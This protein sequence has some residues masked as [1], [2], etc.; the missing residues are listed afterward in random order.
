MTELPEDFSPHEAAE[1]RAE[2]DLSPHEASSAAATEAIGDP[3][4]DAATER[5]D[6]LP[7]RPIDEHPEVFE[8]VHR[9][10]AAA[11]DDEPV[12]DEAGGADDES[13]A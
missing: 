1:G 13:G 4:V 6:D 10:L 9:D 8:E 2:R 3:R 12:S 11:L 5:L 7:E